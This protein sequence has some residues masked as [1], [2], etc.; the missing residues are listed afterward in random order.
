MY[1][2]SE[3]GNTQVKCTYLKI[4]SNCTLVNVFSYIPSLFN[5]SVNLIHCVITRVNWK[6][7][8]YDD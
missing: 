4:V 8:N 2:V 6:K 1:K 3:N 5:S 7:G